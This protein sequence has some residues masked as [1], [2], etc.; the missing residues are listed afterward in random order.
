[1]KVIWI[2][3]D[4]CNLSCKYCYY[5]SWLEERLWEIDIQDIDIYIKKLLDLSVDV[6]TLS[7]GEVFR[8][9]KTAKNTLYLCKQL[10]LNNI[11]FSISTNWT[12][13]NDNIISELKKYKNFKWFFISLDSI[14]KSENDYLRGKTYQV[15]LNIKKIINYW[16][17]LYIL[18]TINNKNINSLE[19]TYSELRKI[20]V[21]NIVFNPAAI[22]KNSKYY[23]EL[24]IDLLKNNHLNDLLKNL[25]KLNDNSEYKDFLNNYYNFW[26]NFY[27]SWKVPQKLNCVMWKDVFIIDSKWN[28]KECF[29]KNNILWNL[30][31]NNINNIKNNINN[32]KKVNHTYKISKC[33]NKSCLCLFTQDDC[34]INY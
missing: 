29:T 1:M 13:L 18:V 23:N 2:V 32:V 14:I 33:I 12:N 22:P 25:K 21:N 4:L 7:W 24:S 17:K 5:N 34:F 20:W 6:V 27:K 8:C 11:N 16:I 30:K 15:L 26:V 9:E 31:F 3:T 10:D 28:I 19:L